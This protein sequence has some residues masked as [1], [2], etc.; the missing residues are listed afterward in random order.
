MV[1]SVHVQAVEV[2][3]VVTDRKGRPVKALAKC[4]ALYSEDLRDRREIESLTI[5]NLF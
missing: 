5:V 3:V 1:D 4:K 2:E